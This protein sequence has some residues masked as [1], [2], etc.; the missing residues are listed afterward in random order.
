MPG[1]RVDFEV[2]HLAMHNRMTSP[3]HGSRNTAR[4][5]SR[6]K[7]DSFDH[8]GSAMDGEA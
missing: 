4:T 6:P 1:E 8:E 7:R 3:M 5:L 2:L